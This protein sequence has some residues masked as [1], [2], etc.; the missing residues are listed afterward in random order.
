[1]W[2][3][4]NLA[5]SIPYHEYETK[6]V[7]DSRS[8]KAWILP[9]ETCNS[10]QWSKTNSRW[11]LAIKDSKVL[12]F[13]VRKSSLKNHNIQRRN[14]LVKRSSDASSLIAVQNIQLHSRN[15]SDGLLMQSHDIQ[16]TWLF[17]RSK[18]N[19]MHVTWMGAHC[20]QTQQ[21]TC[22]QSTGLQQQDTQFH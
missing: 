17:P 20:C 3:K 7:T 10:S 19:E 9:S 13:P 15:L 4:Q 11:G 22:A 14:V 5:T 1:M 18:V 2:N 21:R 16:S 6:D 8:I 12:I